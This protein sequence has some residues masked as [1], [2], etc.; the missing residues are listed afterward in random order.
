M[1][2]VRHRASRRRAACFLARPP[3]PAL[4][5]VPDLA[6]ETRLPALPRCSRHP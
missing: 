1:Q 5:R 3:I 4:R 2:D 6:G